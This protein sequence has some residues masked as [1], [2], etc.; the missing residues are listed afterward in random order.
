MTPEQVDRRARLGWAMLLVCGALALAGCPG[1][2]GGE[3]EDGTDG[4]MADAGARGPDGGDID[5]AGDRGPGAVLD[6]PAARD[7]QTLAMDISLENTGT[8]TARGN[9]FQGEV[10]EV[11]FTFVS[12]PVPGGEWQHKASLYVPTTLSPEAVDGAVA[13]VPAGTD[14]PVSGVS[15][16]GAFRNNYAAAMTAALG[17][18]SM[19]VSGLPGSVDAG[20]GPTDWQQKG[21]ARCTAGP[22]PPQRYVPCMLA[23]LQATDDLQADPFRP[24]AYGWMR[25]VSAAIEAADRLDERAFPE[26][27]PIWDLKLDRAVILADGE[28]A[29][30]ARMAAAVD[31]RIAGVFGSADFAELPALLEQMQTNWT[32]DFGWFDIVGAEAFATWMSGE[33]GSRWRGTVDPAQWSELLDGKAFVNARGTQDPRFPLGAGARLTDHFP[34]DTRRVTAPNYGAGIGSQA[35]LI[36]WYAFVGHVFLDAAWNDLQ[37][38]TSRDGG[39]VVLDMTAVGEGPVEGAAVA[40]IQQHRMADDADYRDAVWQTTEATMADGQWSAGYAPVVERAAGV[41]LMQQS[42]MLPTIL[43]GT[44]NW[45]LKP[46]WSGRIH[47]SD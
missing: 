28:A 43:D 35:H 19:V 21:P 8:L 14:N 24:I 47:L 36:G 32:T 44:Q 22:L 13:I 34:G 26:E 2:D 33:A 18:P 25:A 27:P 20:A 37:T 39:N 10:Y 30:G 29:V 38:F 16:Q 42:M 31:V 15:S 41:G 45:S 7:R 17:I 23:I 5:P 46:T 4:G 11:D 9:G 1:D 40:W 3:A 6:V 12:Q